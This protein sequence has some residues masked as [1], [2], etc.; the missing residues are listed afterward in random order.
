MNIGLCVIIKDEAARI[1]GCLDGIVGEFDDVV[2]IDTGSTDGSTDILRREFGITPIVRLLSDEKCYCKCDA[3]NEGFARLS[4]DWVFILDADE[5][6]DPDRLAGVLAMDDDPAVHG[7]FC[8]W[9]TYK[10]GETIEDYKLALFR[11][12]IEKRGMIHDNAQ[13]EF[14]RRGLD[15]EWLSGLAIAHYPDPGRDAFKTRV[16]KDRLLCALARDP[17]WHRYDW[18]LGYMH[19]R[20][21]RWPDAVRHLG[22][23]AE[24]DSPAFPVESLNARIVLAEVFAAE[25]RERELAE[26]LAGALAF[27]DRV[28][29]DFEVRINFRLRPW[30]EQAEA[31]RRAGRLDAIRAY[32]FA[33]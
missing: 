14:R 33:C 32:A 13:Y 29:D 31:D 28:H 15:A 20:E 24:A 8:R 23:A 9:D 25:R 27:H 1:R 21:G 30:L 11:R 17:D 4:T 3:L 12:G 7:Y 19:F 5:R 10:N 16:Y 2:V 6:L 22:R 18:F 26:T